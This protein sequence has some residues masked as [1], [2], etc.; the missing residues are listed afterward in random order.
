M[1][2]IKGEKLHHNNC[3]LFIVDD[4]VAG[5]IELSNL[6]GVL[7][8]K[9]NCFENVFE[10]IFEIKT[11]LKE[12]NFMCTEKKYFT[13]ISFLFLENLMVIYQNANIHTHIMT[14]AAF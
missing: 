11:I 1:S 2:K 6:V 4:R 7:I 12:T 13:E 5:E 3:F 10:F 9:I 14:I 8:V